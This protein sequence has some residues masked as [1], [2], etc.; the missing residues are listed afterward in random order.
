MGIVIL[1]SIFKNA[2]KEQL[3]VKEEEHDPKGKFNGAKEVQ[4]CFGSSYKFFI[5]STHSAHNSQQPYD[6][7]HQGHWL[8]IKFEFPQTGK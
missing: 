8:N 6:E 3:S 1:H 2:V 4:Y 7:M 5:M